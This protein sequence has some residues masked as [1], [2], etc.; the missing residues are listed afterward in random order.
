MR[1]LPHRS[2]ITVCVVHIDPLIAAGIVATLGEHFKVVVGT[3]GSAL[4]DT[5]AQESP[6]PDVLVADYHSGLQLISSPAALRNRVLI[7][8]RDGEARICRALEQ[9]ARGY[10]LTGCSLNCLIDGVRT[11]HAGGLAAE[12]LVIG[13]IAEWM[14]QEALTAREAD[15]LGQL[16]LGL[17]NK[18]IASRLTMTEGTV[19]THVKSILKKL[20]ASSRTAAAAIAQRRGILQDERPWVPP[21]VS[22]PPFTLRPSVIGPVLR[23]SHPPRG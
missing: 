10:L 22:Q 4:A 20:D 6:S 15:V 13:R 11:V 21:E 9:G 23:P 14:K 3:P 7:L 16:M 17:S 2:K 19:K 18:G 12:P 8:D 5:T 1:E